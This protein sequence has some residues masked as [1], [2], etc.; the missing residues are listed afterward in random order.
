MYNQNDK[1]NNSVTHEVARPPFGMVIGVQTGTPSTQ[2]NTT[3]TIRFQSAVNQYV[4]CASI[5][6]SN[7]RPFDRDDLVIVPAK[8]GDIVGC[9]WAGDQVAFFIV[10]GMATQNCAGSSVSAP[11]SG[12]NP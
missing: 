7:R 4:D 11:I 2:A 6:P 3:Y 5:K 1:L 8:V 9:Y 10:E 12:N